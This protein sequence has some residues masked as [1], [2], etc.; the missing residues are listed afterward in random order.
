MLEGKACIVTGANSGTGKET[1]LALVSMKAEVL[2]VCR[3][4][5]KGEAAMAETKKRSGNQSFELLLC[6]LSSLDQVRSLAAD[7]KSRHQKL[8]VLVNNAGLVSF[9]GKTVDGYETTPGRS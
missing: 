2:L 3:S 4:R 1:A 8:S 9:T 6:D 5:E 7:V